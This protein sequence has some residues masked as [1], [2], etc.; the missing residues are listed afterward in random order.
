[1]TEQKETN[2]PT[3]PLT[4]STTARTGA[5]S[6]KSDATQVRQ[7]FSHGRTRAVTV[8]VK[9]PAK[10]TSGASASPASPAA[11]PAKPPPA[12]APST[13]GGRTL[14]LGGGAASRPA[15][16]RPDGGR[17]IVLRTLTE[18]EKE[19]RA[20][21]LVDANRE[22][23]VARQRAAEEAARRAAEEKA[24]KAAEEEHKRRLAE[25]EA[26]R[27]AEEEMKRKADVMVQKRLDQAASAPQTPIA[28]QA[29]EIKAG[30]APSTSP[31]QPVRR[32]PGA[33][34]PAGASS[35]GP[36]GVLR[37]PPMRPAINKRLPQPPGAR[38]EAPKR[39][40]DKID[41]A[42]AVAGENDFRSRSVAQQR[43]R[44]ERERRREH[45]ND[46]PQ[47][48]V[49]REVTI[50]ETITVQEL[51]SRMSE[52]G[53]DVIKT[54]MRMGVMA[55]INHAIDADTAE[56][57]VTEMGH[58]PKR[59][60]EGDVE[61]GLS[62]M[63]DPEGSQVSR[64]P[65]VTI[66]GHVDHGKTSLLDALRAT[67]VAAHEAGGITQHIGAYQVTL[68]SQQKITFLDT[69]GHEAFTAMRARGAKVTDIVVLVVAGDDGVMPQTKEAIAH[70][71]SAGVPMIV[72]INK[73]DKPGA[74]ASRVRT[75]LL[76]DEVQVE[77]LGGDVQSIEVSAV[78]KTNL[79]KLEEAILLQAEV[80]ELRANPNRPADGVVVEAKLDPGRGP[81][82]TVLV[83]RG[84]LKVGDVLVA[85]SVWGRVRRLLDDRGSA[86][87][88]AGPAFPVEILGLD[89]TPQAGDEFHVVESEARAREVADFRSRRERQAQLARAA[90]GRGTLEEMLKGIREGTA[91]ELPVLIKADVQGSAEALAGAI[92]RLS[93][94]KVAA[95]VIYSGVGG[96]S[97]A[98]ITLA[99]ASGALIIGF[100]VRANPQAREI[101]RRDKVDIRYYSIIYKVTEDIQSLMVGLLEPTF[102]ETFLGN[103]QIREVFRITKVGNVAGCMVTEGQVKRGAKVRLLRD[104]VVIHE[105]TLKTLRRFKDEVRE[106]QHGF[107][108]GMAF[109]NY[110]DIKVGDVIE[111]FEVE[112]VRP[113]L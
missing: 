14:K 17:G 49:Y 36:G 84:T 7:K 56:L 54:L 32:P 65:V 20:R 113:T 18:E 59:V 42:R 15:P 61:L 9:K 40:S 109:E 64:P 51:A 104:N 21:A 88:S 90:G 6:S 63:V 48:K 37:R 43:R 93:T 24:R 70:A 86:V 23:E 68:P 19:A 30:A 75:E 111:C 85:G 110:D 98:D 50:P 92:S 99:K 38:R 95:R 26:R 1:M 58:R 3:K 55:T 87:D 22:A 107:E 5:S 79:D 25:E 102:K 60:A 8:E 74:D 78:K 108:C 28:R 35:T 33:P 2:K 69:P 11:S 106:V 96:I 103:A 67:D 44:L 72:A 101:A 52:R 13:G 80:L 73:M 29:D 81:V 77:Q 34:A 41:V 105:G 4:L 12:A 27:K 62:D 89:G 82:A 97:E 57:V 66:M 45:A 76:Q 16:T 46:T 94:E 10:R 100:N 53:A 71:K 83:Q 47:Q 112:E 91:K 31:A 39:R